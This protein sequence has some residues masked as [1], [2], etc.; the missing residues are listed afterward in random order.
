MA[1]SET[2]KRSSLGDLVR[3]NHAGQPTAVRELDAARFGCR[4]LARSLARREARALTRLAGVVGVPKLIALD[5]DRLVRSYL[6]G[7]A[8]HRALPHS[9]AYFRNALRLLRQMHRRGVAHNDLAKEANWICGPG[10]TAGIVDFQLACCPARRTRRFRLL[11][12]ED[13]RH[14]LKHKAHYRPDTL[15]DRQQ[16]LL[17]TPAWPARLWRTAFKPVYRLLTRGL[18]GW[19]ERR[20]A[21]ERERPGAD[22]RRRPT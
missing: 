7:E 16:R 3:R 14:W 20:S 6:D 17:A 1:T 19:P 11:A 8:M 4:W 5:R 22:E 15:T 12:R 21:A 9:R 13:L 10:Q 18:L 2:L